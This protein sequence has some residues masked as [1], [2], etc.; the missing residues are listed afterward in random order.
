M[1]Q[2]CTGMKGTITSSLTR[3]CTKCTHYIAPTCFIFCQNVMLD[4]IL[5]QHEMHHIFAP[6]L[7]W[8]HCTK[9]A[10]CCIEFWCSQVPYG[11]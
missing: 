10:F 6:Y 9:S 3:I 8:L 11:E 2:Y 5:H 4:Y 7:Q 1:S